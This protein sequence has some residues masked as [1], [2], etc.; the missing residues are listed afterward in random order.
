M[1]IAVLIMTDIIK[2]NG[3]NNRISSRKSNRIL[4]FIKKTNSLA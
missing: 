4:T 2:F 3:T 1:A